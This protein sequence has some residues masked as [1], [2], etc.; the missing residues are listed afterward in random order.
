[1]TGDA[2]I[3]L[4]LETQAQTR[5]ALIVPYVRSNSPT[6]IQ[7]SIGFDSQ[8]SS[9]RSRMSQGGTL[10]LDGGQAKALGQLAVNLDG[11]KDCWLKIALAQYGRPKTTYDFSCSEILQAKNLR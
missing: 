7:Y 10:I 11:V 8:G 5:P 9:G 3:Q 2:D 1:M 4:W 6:E